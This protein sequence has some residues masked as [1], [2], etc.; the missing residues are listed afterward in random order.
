MPIPDRPIR[1][2]LTLVRGDTFEFTF[3]WL[4]EP[5]G[6]GTRTAIDLTGYQARFTVRRPY[7]DAV[8]LSATQ[9]DGIT[10]NADAVTGR[11]RIT[12]QPAATAT[13]PPGEHVWDLEFTTPSG[14]VET[15]FLGSFVVLPDQSR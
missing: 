4:S 14:K 7:T 15:V 8:I 10:L 3:R 9:A 6:G 13:L 5:P 12:R 2:A 11:C 1:L